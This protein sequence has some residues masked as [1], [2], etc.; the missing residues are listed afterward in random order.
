MQLQNFEY[1]ITYY[2]ISKHDTSI[3]I[4]VFIRN[5]ESYFRS[6]C[7]SSFVCIWKSRSFSVIC[8]GKSKTFNVIC[9]WKSKSFNKTIR[10][11]SDGSL[12]RESSRTGRTVTSNH[13]CRILQLRR[14]P[15][16]GNGQTALR[17]RAHETR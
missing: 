8:A 1:Q 12:R 5:M 11:K 6:P 10:Y 2:S 4:V 9:F 17:I 15:R 14:T 3:E 7:I 13:I 16:A